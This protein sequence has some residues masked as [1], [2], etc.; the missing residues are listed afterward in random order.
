MDAFRACAAANFAIVERIVRDPRYHGAASDDREG[1]ARPVGQK[2]SVCFT[3]A[4]DTMSRAEASKRAVAAGY[5]VK[6]SVAK[7]LTYLVTNDSESGSSKNTKARQLGIKIITEKE[8]LGL[9]GGAS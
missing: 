3:G 4:L 8:F 6:S 2:G 9:V 1:E 5:E 7:G